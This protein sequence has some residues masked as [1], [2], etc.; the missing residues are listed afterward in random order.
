MTQ[1]ER[2]ATKA[3]KLAFKDRY[4]YRNRGKYERIYPLPDE[5]IETSAIAREE[6]ERYDYLIACS[7]EVW[8]EQMSGG[9]VCAKK[10]IDEL[11]KRYGGYISLG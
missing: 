10:K 2:E 11:E 4:E 7:K 6:Q 1:E 5:R 8:G 9:G 3:K